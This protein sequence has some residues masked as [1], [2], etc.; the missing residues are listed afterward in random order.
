MSFRD[1]KLAPYVYIIIAVFDA[2]TK[3]AEYNFV[4]HKIGIICGVISMVVIVSLLI[5]SEKMR[6]NLFLA[7]SSF[8]VYACHILILSP[9]G[10]A[11]Y[12]L[13]QFGDDNSLAWLA[14]YLGVPAITIILCLLF[15]RALKMCAPC[16]LKV[17]NGGR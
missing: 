14:Y 5:E 4:I 6:E 15:Y 9:L 17:L 11:L 3:N 2:M 16:L 13:F 10:K 12:A 8:F 1:I 7:K